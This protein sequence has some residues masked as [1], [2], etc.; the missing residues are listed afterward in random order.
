MNLNDGLWHHLTL[1]Y[2]SHSLRLYLDGILIQQGFTG[3]FPPFV[4]SVPLHI[5]GTASGQ[6]FKG[7]IDSVRIYNRFFSPEE[8]AALYL[9]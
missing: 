5:G 8:V 7:S 4:N 9:R 6:G 2:D 1:T 3:A